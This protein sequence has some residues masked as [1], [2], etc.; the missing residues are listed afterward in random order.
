MQNLNK[1]GLSEVVQTS[2]LILLSISA[3]FTL[4]SYVGDLTGD[5]EETLSPVVD[6]INMKSE[7]KGACINE[8]GKV[9]VTLNK[10]LGE[11]I[12]NT[13]FNLN[14][15]SF[16]C[17]NSCASCS[18]SEDKNTQKIY[19][20]PTNQ[21]SAGNSLIVSINACAPEILELRNC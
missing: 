15:E 18:I 11:T 6:C 2:L 7:I 13:E 17:D 16:S 12:T 8:D 10:A 14:G 3:I 19:L 21:I 1:K 5:F 20:T 4:W 9:E